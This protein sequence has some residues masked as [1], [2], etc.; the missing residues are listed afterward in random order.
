M[1]VEKLATDTVF[2]AAKLAEGAVKDTW[3]KLDAASEKPKPSEFLGQKAM[4]AIQ[5]ITDQ[6][7]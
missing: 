1:P 7:K 5:G 3:N 2:S 6:N 4:R